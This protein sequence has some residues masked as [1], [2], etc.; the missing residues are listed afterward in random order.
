MLY[1]SNP[2]E[3]RSILQEALEISDNC[4]RHFDAVE[5]VEMMQ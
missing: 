1:S 4:L 2:D 3:I 5:E